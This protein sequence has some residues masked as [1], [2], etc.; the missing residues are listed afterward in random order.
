MCARACVCMHAC[1]H[2]IKEFY[3]LMCLLLSLLAP[4]MELDHVSLF[5]RSW[6]KGESVSAI[7]SKVKWC[8]HASPM[9]Q[10]TCSS[11]HVYCDI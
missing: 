5:R 1:M 8:V 10:A 9:G 2:L 4:G 3:L 6:E 7:I 11:V